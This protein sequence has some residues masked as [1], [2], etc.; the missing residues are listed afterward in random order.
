MDLKSLKEKAQWLASFIIVAGGLSLSSPPK[1][2]AVDKE[3][4]A[5]I[6]QLFDVSAANTKSLQQLASRMSKLEAD[7]KQLL[8]NQEHLNKNQATLNQNQVDS[9]QRLEALEDNG[10]SSSSS[11]EP[12]PAPGTL[13]RLS[14]RVLRRN[15]AWGIEEATSRIT[16]ILF[17]GIFGGG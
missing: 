13:K 8:A 12:S 14:M 9:V 10:G 2:L 4:S 11:D 16:N 1:G 17:R 7:Q 3:D 5:A 15:I 6:V